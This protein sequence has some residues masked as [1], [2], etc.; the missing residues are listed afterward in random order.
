MS[1]YRWSSMGRSLFSFFLFSFFCFLTYKDKCFHQYMLIYVGLVSILILTYSQ[2]ICWKWSS[3]R[4]RQVQFHIHLQYEKFST[5]FSSKWLANGRTTYGKMKWKYS[6]LLNLL[7]QQI[8]PSVFLVTKHW[9]NSKVVY[10][11]QK[12]DHYYYHYGLW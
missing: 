1:I 6:G 10:I 7:M 12:E 4:W 8:S 3:M 9:T 5:R 2:C 11:Q